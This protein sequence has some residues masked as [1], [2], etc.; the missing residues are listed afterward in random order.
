[1]TNTLVADTGVVFAAFDVAD[2]DHEGCLELLGSGAA[3]IV[4]AP[5]V[6]ELDW[7]SSSRR[8]PAA[9][10][11]LLSS[12]VD[13]SVIVADLEREDYARA[14]ELILRYQDLPLG[15]VDASIIAI[16]ERLEQDTIA[17]LDHRHF[18]V[19]R[20]THVPAFTLLP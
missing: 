8:V 12:I 3:V 16:A 10:V 20:P 4:P 13:G 17:T 11:F 2:G 14:L 19:V 18:S 5:V 7:L 1:M 15:L 9:S 6:V